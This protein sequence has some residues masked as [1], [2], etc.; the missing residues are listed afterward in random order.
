MRISG[1]RP[2]L[3]RNQFGGFGF[4]NLVAVKP[5]PKL[6]VATAIM[7]LTLGRDVRLI[8]EIALDEC[9]DMVRLHTGVPILCSSLCGV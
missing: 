3:F 2:A 4:P 5:E 7:H 1:S 8:S 6:D 9:R